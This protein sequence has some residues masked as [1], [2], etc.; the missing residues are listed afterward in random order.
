[1]Q[2]AAKAKVEQSIELI[3]NPL[4]APPQ[5]GVAPNQPDSN[6]TDAKPVS[7][8]SMPSVSMSMWRDPMPHEQHADFA[9][10]SAQLDAEANKVWFRYVLP[11]RKKQIEVLAKKAATASDS[12]LKALKAPMQEAGVSS[13]A[14]ALA[15]IYMNGRQSIVSERKSQLGMSKADNPED[16]IDP[17]TK[18][19]RSNLA[20]LKNTAEV[21]MAGMGMALV[22][23]AVE[24]AQLARNADMPARDVERSVFT[25]LTD[26]SEPTV[27]ADL[28]GVIA[29]TFING[30]NE[31]ALSMRSDL[32]TAYYSAIMDQNTCDTCAAFDGAEHDPEDATFSTP[33]PNCEGGNRCRCVTIYIFRQQAA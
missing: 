3:T 31:Q 13:L 1:M 32:E 27:K 20:W 16:N 25:A 11:V 33:N 12:D 2:D 8:A 6:S 5:N 28:A 17:E 24:S 10:M 23:R 21:F 29:Q 18:P 4:P 19:T 26:L 22:K 15:P 30:R 9:K 7:K 14:R